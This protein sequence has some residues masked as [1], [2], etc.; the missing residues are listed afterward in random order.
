M[1]YNAVWNFVGSVQYSTISVE[2]SATEC[3]VRLFFWRA[4]QN[5]VFLHSSRSRTMLPDS[6]SETPHMSF[7]CF[8]PFTGYLLSRASNANCLC[9]ALRSSLIKP[10]STFQSVLTF[11]FLPS[12]FAL[13]KTP[14]CLPSFRI[15]S[16]GQHSFSDQN[17]GSN[18]I[19]KQ[20]KK[21]PP[22]KCLSVC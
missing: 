22:Q 19:N 12:S 18:Y 15:K 1:S 16:S 21:C 6:F 7:L 8:T 17:P 4:V 13:L 5:I 11:A 9:L 2:M 10:R 14:A 3:C 20:T